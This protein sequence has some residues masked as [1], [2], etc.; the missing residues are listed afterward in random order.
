M[1]GAGGGGERGPSSFFLEKRGRV[2]PWKGG[3]AEKG[4][5][6]CPPHSLR[7]GKKRDLLF[8]KKTNSKGNGF[9]GKRK[10]LPLKREE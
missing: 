10:A 8:S 6:S 5:G 9:S 7:G 2:D 1:P 4:E 3:E